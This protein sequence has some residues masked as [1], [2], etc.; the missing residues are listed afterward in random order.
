MRDPHQILLVSGCLGFLLVVVLIFGAAARR[1]RFY[2][3][4][5]RR[6]KQPPAR[7][8]LLLRVGKTDQHVDLGILEGT[9]E[10]ARDAASSRIVNHLWK[11]GQ[12]TGPF[13]C[14]YQI[15]PAEEPPRG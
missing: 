12:L 13:A 4:Y 8:R 7:W 15:V 1:S 5:V 9:E 14:D 3:D 2:R 6:N 10:E 11:S